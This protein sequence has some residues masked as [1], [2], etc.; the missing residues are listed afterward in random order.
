MI[1]RQDVAISRK[2]DTTAWKIK[3]NDEVAKHK[4][5]CSDYDAM[6]QEHEDLKTETKKAA[7]ENHAKIAAQEKELAV[8]RSNGT[9]P[10]FEKDTV[11]K[12]VSQ[13][14]RNGEAKARI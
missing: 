2:E 12:A 9:N 3:Y 5:S 10:K 8:R 1:S 4:T 6:S 11:S 14:G 13:A 7:S